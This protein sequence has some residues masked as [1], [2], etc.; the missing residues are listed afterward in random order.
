MI[1]DAAFTPSFAYAQHCNVT[2]IPSAVDALL[3]H[4]NTNHL[5]GVRR[6]G[7]WYASAMDAQ[8]SGDKDLTRKD[9]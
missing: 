8:G 1:T 2:S 4:D 6:K 5:F 3:A 9:R 7:L